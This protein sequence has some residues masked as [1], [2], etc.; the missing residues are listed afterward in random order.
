TRDSAHQ[1]PRPETS[2]SQGDARP[3][4]RPDLCL[5]LESTYEEAPGHKP[6]ENEPEPP[7]HKPAGNEPERKPDENEAEPDGHKPAENKP[8][9][10][11][12]PAARDEVYEPSEN[13]PQ[14]PKLPDEPTEGA[15][16]KRIYRVMKPRADGSFLIPESVRKDCVNKETRHNVVHLFEKCAWDV[17]KFTIKC[18][19]LVEE[20]DEL[21]V[22]EDYEFLTEEDMHDLNWSEERISGV[23]LHCAK[24]PNY[25]RTRLY[26]NKTMYWSN[27][28][29][30]GKKKNVKRSM[31]QRMI[32][33]EEDPPED[34]KLKS[35]TDDFDF[36]GFEMADKAA[37]VQANPPELLDKKLAGL[38]IQKRLAKLDG[39]KTELSGVIQVLTQLPKPV[40]A[41]LAQQMST[42][43]E[44]LRKQL[45][46][47]DT[48]LISLYN[49]GI[50]DGYSGECVQAMLLEPRAKQGPYWVAP[51]EEKPEP[52]KRGREGEGDG[53]KPAKKAMEK[54]VVLFCSNG[55]KITE[56]GPWPE[57]PATSIARNVRAAK[58]EGTKASGVESTGGLADNNASRDVDRLFR[59]FGLALKVP[60]DT[61]TYHVPDTTETI[62]IPW[63][64]PTAWVAFMLDKYPI[65]FTGCEGNF[66]VQLQSFWTCYEQVHPGHVVFRDRSRLSRTLPLLVHGDE[67]RY[68][69]RSN[70]MICT[71]ESVLGSE[72]QTRKKCSCCHDPCLARYSDFDVDMDPSMLQA[73]RVAAKQHTNVKGH[74][75]LSK[76]LCFGL[77]KKQYADQPGLLDYAFQVLAEDMT[78]L[79]H[80]GVIVGRICRVSRRVS[81]RSDQG[82]VGVVSQPEAMASDDKLEEF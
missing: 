63:I 62:D 80:D 50:I 77:A 38:S 69:K 51:K 9:P 65:F 41:S 12:L 27:L 61:I 66:E 2:T 31:T 8:E 43:I 10:P 13:E 70:F 29:V 33:W 11:K 22:E 68:L 20:I 7:G 5:L 60:R 3:P 72:P 44:E 58:L 26:D 74:P 17:G 1:E 4:A 18:R 55:L 54:R 23:K 75:Y 76:F 32:D 71:V 37:A 21:E 28:K 81:A 16:Y 14:P 45:D 73:V 39:F 42:K 15:V 24:F 59:R 52:P 34:G 25:V 48:K 35:N 46:E 30:R 47:S 49:Q 57:V 53:Q 36:K 82:H 79:F 64:R 40:D 67:G 6:A 78:A 19:K 56:M